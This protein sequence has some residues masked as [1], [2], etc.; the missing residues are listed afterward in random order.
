VAGVEVVIEASF[1]SVTT[2]DPLAATVKGVVNV[3]AD[4]DVAVAK[5]HSTLLVVAEHPV[6]AV[7]RAEFV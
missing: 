6:W 7:E 1:V 3:C 4:P 2:S 5:F